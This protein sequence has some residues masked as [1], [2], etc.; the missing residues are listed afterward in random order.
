M[1]K[2]A[3]KSLNRKSLQRKVRTI[4]VFSTQKIAEKFQNN[5]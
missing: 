2:F 5:S 3:E 1:E 4:H